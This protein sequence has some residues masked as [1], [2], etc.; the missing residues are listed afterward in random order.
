MAIGDGDETGTHVRPR[1]EVVGAVIERHNHRMLHN[2]IGQLQIKGIF[3]EVE[4]GLASGRLPSHLDISIEFGDNSFHTAE[5][6]LFYSF[7]KHL[8]VRLEPLLD[9]W[10]TVANTTRPITKAKARWSEL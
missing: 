1:H 7:E 3:N 8:H 10:G 2:S 4:D 5:R 9:R 6:L